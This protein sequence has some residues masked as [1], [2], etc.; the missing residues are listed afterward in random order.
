MSTLLDKRWELDAVDKMIFEEDLKIRSVYFDLELDLM[1]I[2]LSNKKILKRSI[3][4]TQRLKKASEQ[5]LK[6]FE[7]S[8]TGIHWPEL[9]EDLSLR[10]FLKEE[11]LNA[12]RESIP[13]TT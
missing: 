10:G 2:V 7:I 4:I 5:Q 6:N 9:D 11:M 13:L 8:R 3:G 12:I 1:L